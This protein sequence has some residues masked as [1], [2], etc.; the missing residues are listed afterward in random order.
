MDIATF[1]ELTPEEAT[2]LLRPCADVPTW[3]AELV[4]GRP[5]DDV[6]SL[7]TFADAAACAWGATE[8]DSALAHHPRIG[9]RASGGSAEAAMSQAEQSGISGREQALAEGNRTYEEIFGRIFLIRAAGRSIDDVLDQLTQRL[10]NDPETET[11]VVAGE[12]REIAV[13][14]LE[15]MFTS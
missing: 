11:A 3:L 8:I 12:L 2:E 5:Y 14:R 4:T 6:A 15:G 7:V 9:E 13:L 10:D 1:N